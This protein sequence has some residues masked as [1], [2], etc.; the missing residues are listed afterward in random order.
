MPIGKPLGAPIN[1]GEEAMTFDL[2]KLYKYE[3]NLER[4]AYESAVE[5]IQEFFGV[6]DVEDLLDD[7]KRSVQIYVNGMDDSGLM[8]PGFRQVLCDWGIE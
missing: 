1:H 8:Y 2:P 5:A 6:D 7:Q 3:E 4:I